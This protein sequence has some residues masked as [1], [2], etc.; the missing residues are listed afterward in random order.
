[1]LEFDKW[2]RDLDSKYNIKI[3]CKPSSYDW[4]WINCLY[5][6]FGPEKKIRLPFSCMC[7]STMFKTAEMIG[8]KRDEVTKYVKNPV[9][10]HTHFADDDAYEQGYS[11][12]KLCYFLKQRFA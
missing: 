6:E 7:L 4:Q 12:L 3:V 2:Y 11:Y 8:C 9:V 10:M 5:D 1:M